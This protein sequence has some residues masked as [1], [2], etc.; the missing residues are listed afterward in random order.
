VETWSLASDFAV[1]PD[2]GNPNPDSYG[3]AAV[4]SFLQSATL[5]HDPGGY[6]GLPHFLTDA[7]SL[8]GLQAWQGDVA[9]GPKA[10]LPEVAFNARADAAFPF[11]SNI[12]SHT[13]MVHPLPDRLVVVGWRSRCPAR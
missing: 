5:A 4:W 3:N 7:A 11:G 1:A 10:G 2:Q 13:V 9:D 12:P 8:P 6:S